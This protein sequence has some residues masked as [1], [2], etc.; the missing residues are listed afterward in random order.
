MLAKS[1]EVIEAWGF[2]YRTC[3]VWD[4]LKIGMGYWARNRHELLLIC[5]RGHMPALKIGDQPH[6]VIRVPRGMHSFKHIEFYEIIEGAYPEL[7]KIELFC[8]SPRKG[9][10]VWGNQAGSA[11]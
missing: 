7:P 3:M 9:W 5:R 4:K 8:R 11:A 10:A 6:S 1:M 2:E